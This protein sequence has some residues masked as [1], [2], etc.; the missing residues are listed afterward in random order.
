[1][2]VNSFNASNPPLTTKGDLF[3]FSTIPTRVGVG[4]ND[5]V[6][7]ADSTTATGLK[8]AAPASGGMTLIST[9][10]LSGASTTLSSIPQTYNSL[11]LVGYGI[12][13]STNQEFKISIN[14]GTDVWMS[15]IDGATL[16]AYAQ[17]DWKVSADRSI[18]TGSLPFSFYGEINNYTNTSGYKPVQSYGYAYN[19]SGQAAVTSLGGYR[20]T[21]AVTSLVF[22][23]SGDGTGTILVYGVK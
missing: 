12:Y 10:T 1:M 16:S 18:G 4:A 21:S 17:V 2:S 5:T 8:W 11:A 15:G 6:L 20:N 3:T 22:D 7:T 9:V 23:A 13:G 14:G 19:G